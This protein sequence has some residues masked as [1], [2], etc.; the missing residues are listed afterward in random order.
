MRTPMFSIIT[1]CYNAASD[2]ERT[3]QSVVAQT[4]RNIEYIVID[5][6]STDKTL[7]IISKYSA[8]VSQMVSEKD[9]GLYDAMNK[10]LSLATGEYVC[11][12][13]AG[14]SFFEEKT[15]EKIVQGLDGSTPDLIY[16]DTALVDKNG[17]FLRMRRLSPPEKL[18][19]K[20]F[21]RG[22]LV[23]HQ[24]FIPRR[25]IAPMYDLSYKYSSDFDWCIKIMK[26]CTKIHNTHLTLINYLNEGLTTKNHKASLRERYHIMNRH[27]GYIITF[28]MHIWFLIRT[29]FKQ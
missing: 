28:L 27:Y 26:H 4:Y 18:T 12:L 16:G 2:I 19:W 25:T 13:N 9:G 15:L 24:A 1:I 29:V 17:L 8:E 10:G 5:G 11:F 23:C 21:R 7:D 20:S 3:L 22:M 14:D 6:A